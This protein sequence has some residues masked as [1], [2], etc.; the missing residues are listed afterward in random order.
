MIAIPL[1]GLAV[2]ASGY[3]VRAILEVIR[4]RGVC[5]QYAAAAGNSRPPSDDTF[6]GSM[7]A[8]AHGTELG[9]SQ[10]QSPA[11]V[12]ATDPVPQ[13]RCQELTRARGMKT[14][15]WTRR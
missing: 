3:L 10:Q 4:W 11:S 7:R 13:V 6:L 5:S 1:V 14:A 15:E 9:T 8:L 12:A 2:L